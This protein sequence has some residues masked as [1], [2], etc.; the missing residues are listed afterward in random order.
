MRDDEDGGLHGSLGRCLSVSVSRRGDYLIDSRL[1]T[2]SSIN[3]KACE[4]D[5]C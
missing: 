1:P 2:T 3:T 4:Y 5:C